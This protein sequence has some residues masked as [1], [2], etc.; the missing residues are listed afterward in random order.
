MNFKKAI[1]IIIGLIFTYQLT[2]IVKSKGKMFLS[3]RD[4]FN[5]KIFYLKI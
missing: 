2:K 4:E 5:T 1:M 3:N